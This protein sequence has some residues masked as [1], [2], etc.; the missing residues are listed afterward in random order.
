MLNPMLFH[1]FTVVE[2]GRNWLFRFPCE[3]AE[4]LVFDA[5]IGVVSTKR[6]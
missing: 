2:T 3:F 1:R 5:R 6:G 4:V